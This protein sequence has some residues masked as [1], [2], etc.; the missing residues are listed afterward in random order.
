MASVPARVA[1]IARRHPGRTAIVGDDRRIDYAG[2][3]REAQ[4]FARA[5]RMRGLQPGDRVAILLPNRI[6]AAVACYGTWL[7]GGIAAPL[8]VQARERDFQA[9]LA[10][11]DARHAV[12][13][14][15]HGDALAA[16]DTIDATRALPLERWAIDG[17][18]PLL[19]NDDVD[20][21]GIDPTDIDIDPAS[22]GGDDTALILYTSG[23]TGAPKGVTLTH[24]NLL[25]NASAVVR[26][27]ALDERD[28]VLSIL[29]FYYAYG[30]SVL[31]THLISGGCVVLAPNLLFPHLLMDTIARERIT[32]FSGVP[33]TFALLLERVKLADYDLSS[34]RYLTQAGGAMSPVLT[35]RLRAALPHARLF[36]M[37]GQTEA[38]SRLTWLPP[39]RLDEKLGSVGIPVEGVELRIVHEDG[40]DAAIGDIGE[41]RVRGANVMRGYWNNPEASSLVL[42]DGWLRTGDL[43]HLDADGVLWLAGRRSDM[44]K[45]GAH[46]VHPGD[47]EDVIAEMPGVSEV[48][49]VGV[50][51]AVLGQ[52]IKAFVVAPGLPPNSENQIK[53]HCRERLATYKIPRDIAF[54]TALPR[55]A[56]GKVRRAALLATLSE[57]DT[58]S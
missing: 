33:S 29:A 10:H 56:S 26:Y 21:T 7:A 17:E 5:L 15:R 14:M 46:R 34:L 24:G 39:E 23:T 8:N 22:I 58:A 42:V 48:A 49:V 47:I 51:D 13:E 18:H 54:V 36:V 52:V 43:G 27:L 6:E 19:S 20:A 2:F 12:F 35:R 25:A 31:H 45:T 3:W 9:W 30:A 28:S 53:A 37:Y 44:I 16:L 11:C 40:R 50:D 55:T 1:E 32:G 4:R 38:T 57:S 41:V